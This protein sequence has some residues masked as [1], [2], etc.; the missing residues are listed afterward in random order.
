MTLEFSTMFFL[1]RLNDDSKRIFLRLLTSSKASW[2]SNY[3]LNKWLQMMLWFG[4]QYPP[5]SSSSA[6]CLFLIS[7]FIRCRLS[8]K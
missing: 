7:F 8:A 5:E 2:A 4:L 6:L 1:E 3:S